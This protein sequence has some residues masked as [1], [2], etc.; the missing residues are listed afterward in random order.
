MDIDHEGINALL[1]HI[2]ITADQKC[3][4]LLWERLGIGLAQYRILLVVGAGQSP[5]Q[6]VVADRLQVT[7]AAVSRQVKLLIDKVYIERAVNPGNRKEQLLR[8]TGK[9]DRICL[10][11]QELMANQSR[12]MLDALNYRQQKALVVHLVAVHEAVCIDANCGHRYRD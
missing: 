6:R 9:G 4:Q 2:G 3:D 8:T 10:A 11:A 1:A 12:K 5:T 7:E